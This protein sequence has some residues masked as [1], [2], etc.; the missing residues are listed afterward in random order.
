M[1]E[2]PETGIKNQIPRDREEQNTQRQGRN[3][4]VKRARWEPTLSALDTKS[5]R[6]RVSLNRTEMLSITQTEPQ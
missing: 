3:R 4:T 5:D 6:H 2:H 1:K